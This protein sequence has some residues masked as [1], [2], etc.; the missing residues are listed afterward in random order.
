MEL[1]LAHNRLAG[2]LPSSL[3]GLRAL[4][5]FY[6][7]NTELCA[8]LDDAFQGWLQNVLSVRG[9]NCAPD[10]TEQRLAQPERATME[11][12]ASEAAEHTATPAE[13][14]ALRAELQR[15]IGTLRAELRAL[16]LRL[17]RRLND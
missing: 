15:D 14:A 9:A 7:D 8:P 10:A 17:L 11:A 1:D 4:G 6:F 16:E 5:R 12:P 3:T 2:S 13:L